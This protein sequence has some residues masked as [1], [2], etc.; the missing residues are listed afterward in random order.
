[1]DA[2][3]KLGE[4]AGRNGVMVDMGGL[5]PTAHGARVRVSGGKVTVT[6]GP[7]AEAKEVIGGFAVF[8][9]PSKDEAV[10]WTKRFMEAHME[11]WPGW[12]GETEIRQLY[13]GA[14]VPAKR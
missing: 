7:F 11:H 12:E 4:E 3:A 6:D 8:D 1:M 5:M 2:I 9:V 14:P 10:T 13:D